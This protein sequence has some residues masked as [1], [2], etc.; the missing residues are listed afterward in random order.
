[1]ANPLND[2]S[3]A[4]VMSKPDEEAKQGAAV[5]A[6]GSG[7]EDPAGL[8]DT[9]QPRAPAEIEDEQVKMKKSQSRFLAVCCT[10]MVIVVLGGIGIVFA[11][12]ITSL[13]GSDIA[14]SGKTSDTEVFVW[15][16]TDQ[17]TDGTDKD[18]VPEEGKI[19]TQEGVYSPKIT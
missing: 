4:P 5:E 11:I 19:T 17:P 6:E 3:A 2:S 16:S 10:I 18:N 15:G 12:Q 7:N 14:N 13:G 8:N 9:Q 1:M